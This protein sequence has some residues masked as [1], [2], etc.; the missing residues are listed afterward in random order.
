MTKLHDP[1]RQCDQEPHRDNHLDQSEARFRAGPAC[2]R[3]NQAMPWPSVR[4]PQSAVHD[5]DRCK[6]RAA[7]NQA[8]DRCVSAVSR[9]RG[10][11]QR[12]MYAIS[13]GR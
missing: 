3:R 6:V 2:I 4:I 10:V 13:C 1:G 11:S 9:T 5:E 8:T 12:A 7:L